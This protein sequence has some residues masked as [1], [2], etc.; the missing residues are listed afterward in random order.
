L[1]IRHRALAIE[2][3]ICI[4][5]Y[6]THGCG[7]SVSGKYLCIIGV[8]VVEEN[9]CIFLRYAI[10]PDTDRINKHND[11]VKSLCHCKIM[12]ITGL[13]TRKKLAGKC[14]VALEVEMEG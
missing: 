1:A 2:V 12:S 3:L 11:N 4:K 7:I 6:E 10:E 14:R 8:R 13:M 9:R 5:R